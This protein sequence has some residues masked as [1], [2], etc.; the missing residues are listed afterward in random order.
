[1]RGAEKQVGDKISINKD[2]EVKALWKEKA[3]PQ[4]EPAPTPSPDEGKSY[5]I[6]LDNSKVMFQIKLTDKMLKNLRLEKDKKSA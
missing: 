4:P 1:M 2:I 5:K 6:E 3:K